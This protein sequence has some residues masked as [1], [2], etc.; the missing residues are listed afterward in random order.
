M[1]IF[2][3]TIDRHW[4]RTRDIDRLNPHLLI[5]YSASESESMSIVG[6]GSSSSSSSTTILLDA[7]VTA[8]GIELE[9][10]FPEPILVDV[11]RGFDED[12]GTALLACGPD[13]V[14]S[15]AWMRGAVVMLEVVD[16]VTGTGCC[17]GRSTMG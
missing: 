4:K 3:D 6:M 8:C 16:T 7:T 17:V 14:A 12:S 9:I 15:G 2:R 11:W 5:S 10:R 13:G 1:T